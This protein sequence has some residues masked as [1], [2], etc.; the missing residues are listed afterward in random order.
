MKI[1][2]EINI[3]DMKMTPNIEVVQIEPAPFTGET[4]QTTLEA[5]KH[6]SIG[7]ELAEAYKPRKKHVVPCY[8]ERNVH[9]CTRCGAPHR[10]VDKASGVCKEPTCE[11][12][13][14]LG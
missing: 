6:P 1:T 9:H 3:E 11:T 5:F 13:V 10:R 2:I 14:Y 12:G 8:P 4:E 7:E